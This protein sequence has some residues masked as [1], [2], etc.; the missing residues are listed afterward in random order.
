[1]LL[2]TLNVIIMAVGAM[3]KFQRNAEEKLQDKFSSTWCVQL[4]EEIQR[5][6]SQNEMLKCDMET[7]TEW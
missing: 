7:D 4:G 1:M 3:A 5:I 2:T 6:F